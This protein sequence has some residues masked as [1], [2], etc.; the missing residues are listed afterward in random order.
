MLG[1]HYAT[2]RRWAPAFL[3]TFSFQGVPAAASL[4]RAVDILRKM[5]EHRR[6]DSDL[7]GCLTAALPPLI[8]DT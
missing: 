2:V 5:N 7:A 8:A 1:D 6:R 4:L 3:A